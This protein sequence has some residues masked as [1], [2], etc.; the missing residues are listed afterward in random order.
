MEGI[1]EFLTPHRR[2]D[3]SLK[4]VSQLS[5]AET[6]TNIIIELGHEGKIC[7]VEWKDSQGEALLMG[8]IYKH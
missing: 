6:W 8:K 2:R 7:V 3:A 5:Q 4:S 1:I